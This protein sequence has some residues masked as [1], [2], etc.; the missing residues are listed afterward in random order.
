MYIPKHFLIED[1][2]FIEKMIVENS[3]ATLISF[4]EG[5][6]MATH[7]PLQ[8]DAI[9]NVLY[10]HVAR[11]NNQWKQLDGQ[12]VLA[13]FHGPHAYISPTWYETN[14][15]VPT[16][17]YVAVHVYG[18]CTLIDDDEKTL[19]LL[20]ELVEA[21]E[22]IESS[23]SMK[24]VDGSFMKNLSK[25]IVMFQIGITRIEAKAKLSQNH[26]EER[27]LGVITQLEKSTG[28]QDQQIATLMK[29]YL[30]K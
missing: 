4:A 11:L 7:L 5:E 10:G 15:A 16:W 12:K 8:F 27:K 17:N 22:D 25:G 14:K 13:I 30:E 23:Y 28:Q 9:N 21:Y 20:D 26:S 6:P 18:N 19:H 24:A 3:F 1:E 29:Q 2:A